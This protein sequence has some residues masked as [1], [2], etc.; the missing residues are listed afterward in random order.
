MWVI[1]DYSLI[2]TGQAHSGLKGKKGKTHILF[3]S[4]VVDSH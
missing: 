4:A 1:V 3:I 2:L